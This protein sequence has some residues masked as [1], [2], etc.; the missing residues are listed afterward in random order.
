MKRLTRSPCFSRYDTILVDEAQDMT[1][2]QAAVLFG[3]SDKGAVVYL[4]GDARQRM[5]RKHHGA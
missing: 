1:P 4:V 3:Q 5:S 2:A